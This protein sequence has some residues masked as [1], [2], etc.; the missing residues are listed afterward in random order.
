MAM[1]KKA[2]DY[3]LHTRL[4]KHATGSLDEYIQT[5]LK[6]GMSEI[7]FTDHIPLPN[8]L[9]PDHRMVLE[10]VD[11]YL[12]LID[13]ARNRYRDLSILTGIE[14]DFIDG[15]ESYL[16][17]FISS[18]SFDLVIMSVHFIKHWPRNQ[19]VFNFSYTSQ[20]IKHKYHDYFETMVR[21]IRSGLFD[22][23]GHLDLIKRPGYPVLNSNPEDVENIL[24]AVTQQGMSVELNTSGL[25]KPI[26]DCYPSREIM[27]RVLERGIPVTLGSDAHSPDQVGFSFDDL[28]VWLETRNQVKWARYDNRKRIIEI[29]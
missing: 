1:K 27:K 21:G 24:E 15:H 8:G 14:A 13:S 29:A 16:D 23:V 18:Y 4:C 7:C 6:Q 20:S 12:S 2:R 9:D 3:H 11:S 5:A 22:I 19:W 17:D 10:E 26:E 28:S 25:R